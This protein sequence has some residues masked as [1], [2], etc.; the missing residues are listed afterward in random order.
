LHPS[1]QDGAAADSHIIEVIDITDAVPKQ[2]SKP[3]AV[4]TSRYI[5][6]YAADLEMARRKFDLRN[7][8]QD[9][10][11]EA[12]DRKT[13]VAYLKTCNEIWVSSRERNDKR[14]EECKAEIERLM[15]KNATM[16]QAAEQM[17]AQFEADIDGAEEDKEIL[18]KYEAFF[19]LETNELGL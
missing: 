17:H 6:K 4:P 7:Q 10:V 3:V 15:E 11:A 19:K 14:I 9:F 13:K 8:Y 18:A 16:E 2:G 1:R 5:S 12:N